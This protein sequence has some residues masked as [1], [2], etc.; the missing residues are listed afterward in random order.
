MNAYLLHTGKQRWVEKSPSNVR[1]LN[2]LRRLFPDAL[3]LHCI[4]DGRDAV[5]SLVEQKQFRSRSRRVPP[6]VEATITWRR[7]VRLG[8]GW[9]VELGSAYREVRYEEL[10]SEPESTIAGIL[11]FLGEP[12]EDDVLEFYRHRHDWTIDGQQIERPVEAGSVG[13]WRRDMRLRHRLI[14]WLL[15][16]RELRRTGYSWR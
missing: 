13:R 1:H 9:A 3:F 8:Q 14:F 6:H 15:A 4:R 2:L 11:E 5:C 10:V 12:W 7:D 16:G